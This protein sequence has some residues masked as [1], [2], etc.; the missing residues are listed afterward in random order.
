M[1][2]PAQKAKKNVEIAVTWLRDA[3]ISE[4]DAE[5]IRVTVEALQVAV[6]EAE[7]R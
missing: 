1:T 2:D 3:S 6:Q 4:A 7:E 5:A